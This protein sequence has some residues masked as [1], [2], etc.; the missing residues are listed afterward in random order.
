MHAPWFAAWIVAAAL[1]GLQFAFLTWGM[2]E[3]RR[4]ARARLRKR[5]ERDV[6]PRVGL[7]APCR[8]L[9]VGIEANLRA[10]FEQDYSNYRLTFIV[11]NGN[12]PV[13]P[14]LRRL[15]AEHPNVDARLCIAGPATDS[16]QKV[17]NL[18][19]ATADLSSD[20]E[21]LAFVDSDA[22]PH[23]DWLRRLVA[24]LPHANIGAVTGYRLMKPSS[25]ATAQCLLY[26]INTTV[27]SGFGPG[28]HHLVWGGSWAIRREL[29]ETLGVRTAWKGTLSDDFVA[30]RLLHKAGL[31]VDFE[32][33]CMVV[34]PVDGGWR[35]TL[36]FIRRQYVIA[37][38]YAPAWWL[39][40][41]AGTTLPVL[42]FWG[43]LALL[44]MGICQGAEWT[45][46]PA[47][48]CPAYYA[49]NLVRGWQRWQLARLYVP[50]ATPL[51]QRIVWLD[52]WTGPLV[53][54]VNWL[55]I[56]SSLFGSRLKW[57]GIRYRLGRQGRVL[58]IE[59][60]DGDFERTSGDMVRRKEGPCRRSRKRKSPAVV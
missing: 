14:S 59:R 3:S 36:G 8:G 12:D 30:T 38:S 11:E 53:T 28:G 39:L 41:L 47:A 16:G 35:Q 45:W 20:I 60:S 13:C 48:V 21:V 18:W 5:H 46:L 23:P 40:L 55:A 6:E 1:A 52:I 22:R 10:L 42:T 25:V 17:H 31:R 29:F 26:S 44:A 7:F 50:Q 4:F 54:L 9:D 43:G 56:L 49:A 24:R 57:R 19:V 2:W 51:M 32:P 37:R 34:S 58:S 33:A 15:I 27:A